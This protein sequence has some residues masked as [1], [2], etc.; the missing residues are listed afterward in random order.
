MKTKAT[1][2]NL[3]FQ[4]RQKLNLTQE[5]LAE[6]LGCSFSTA[7]R[8]EYGETIAN[9]AVLRNLSVLYKEND[10]K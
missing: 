3:V 6:E 2:E 7:K 10:I 9:K 8:L 4:L 5:Q 1:S